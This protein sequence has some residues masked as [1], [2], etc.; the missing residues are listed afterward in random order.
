[1]SLAYWLVAGLL[2][3]TYLYGGLLKLVRSKDRLRPMMAWVDRMPLR[4]VRVIGALEV[5]GALGLILP[6]LTGMAPGLCVAAAVGLVLL[7]CGGIATHLTSTD[8]RQ[9]ILN[10]VLLVLA[11]AAVPLALAGL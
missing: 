6:P 2:A 7:Q 10:V 11:L 1:M 8:D 9:I 3:V 4:T 5:L